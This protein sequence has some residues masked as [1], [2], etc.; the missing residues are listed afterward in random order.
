MKKFLLRAFVC[1]LLLVP[2]SAL[3]PVALAS[4][5]SPL[6]PIPCTTPDGGPSAP[7]PTCPI[8]PS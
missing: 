4:P 7:L 5:G 3:A 1:T 2:V 8:A 6:P